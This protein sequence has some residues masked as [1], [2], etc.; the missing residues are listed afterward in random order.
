MVKRGLLL[1]IEIHTLVFPRRED[2]SLSAVYWPRSSVE[3]VGLE[4]IQ[5]MITK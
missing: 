5:V 3:G 1:R 2:L 4:P